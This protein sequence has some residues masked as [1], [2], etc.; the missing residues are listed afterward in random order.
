MLSAMQ[1]PGLMV[2]PEDFAK[3][4]LAP[5]FLLSLNVLDDLDLVGTFRIDQHGDISLPIL[6][7]MHVAGETVSEARVQI[8]NEL[9]KNQI[10]KDPQVNLTVL[11]YTVPEVTIIGEVASPGRYPLISATKSRGRLG[12]CRRSYV[13]RRKP[14]A[15]HAWQCRCSDRF[16]SIILV[17]PIRMRSTK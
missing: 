14:S 4:T 16:L 17:Q 9:L 11:E 1:T 15:D 3:L 13:D 5:G 10:L 8:Q 2:V 6:G 12:V 7:T